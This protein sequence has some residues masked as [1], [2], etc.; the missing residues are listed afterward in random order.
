MEFVSVPVPS[1]HVM[2][3]MA[4]LAKL[5]RKVESRTDTPRNDDD[6]QPIG[7]HGWTVGELRRLAQGQNKT[8]KTVGAIMDELAKDELVKADAWLDLDDLAE[9]TGLA[10]GEVKGCWGPFTNHIR[11]TYVA[12]NW[13]LD[14]EWGPVIND[15]YGPVQVYRL[16]REDAAAWKSVRD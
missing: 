10:R 2:A 9:A 7:T 8:T 6:A 13:P 15:S 3:V 5:D 4:F 14:S 1:D 16:S 11:K 12:T